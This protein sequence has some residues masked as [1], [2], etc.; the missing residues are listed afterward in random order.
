MKN[1]FT[2]LAVCF[3]LSSCLTTP[4]VPQFNLCAEK[5]GVADAFKMTIKEIGDLATPPTEKDVR[6]LVKPLRKNFKLDE[7][8]CQGYTEQVRVASKA[9]I[10]RRASEITPTMLQICSMEIDPGITD[11]SLSAAMQEERM[12][13]K[14]ALIILHESTDKC[15]AY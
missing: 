5:Q 14:A 3:V 9:I 8:Q 4:T 12:G 6:Y 15:L 11:V 7:A 10:R 2:I 13:A 1:I